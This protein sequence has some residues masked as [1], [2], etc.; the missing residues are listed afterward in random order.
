MYSIPWTVGLGVTSGIIYKNCKNYETTFTLN[1]AIYQILLTIWSGYNILTGTNDPNIDDA[2]IGYYVYD[3]IELFVQNNHYEYI[4]HHI[5]ALYMIYL[6]KTYYLAPFFYRNLM[7]FLMEMS[8]CVLNWQQ[9]LKKCKVLTYSIFGIT[10]CIIYPIYVV[11]YVRLYYEPYWYY[12][13]HVFSCLVVYVISNIHM[14]V[15]IKNMR[16]FKVILS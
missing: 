11:D 16:D 2:V 4:L 9:L 6:D 12:R 8:A 7:Y 13:I 15:S 3:T 1:A 5:I 14:I 10:R